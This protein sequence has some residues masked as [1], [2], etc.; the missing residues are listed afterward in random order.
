MHSK[1]IDINRPVCDRCGY[2]MSGSR[3]TRCP[4]C[5]SSDMSS[6]AARH[7]KLKATAARSGMILAWLLMLVVV[8]GGHMPAP[9]L[10]HSFVALPVLVSDVIR[11]EPRTFGSMFWASIAAVIAFCIGIL[12]RLLYNRSF[13]IRLIIWHVLSVAIGWVVVAVAAWNAKPA[14]FSIG[15]LLVSSLPLV[16]YFAKKYVCGIGVDIWNDRNIN[17]QAS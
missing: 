13:G 16:V 2:D 3:L 6:A 5:G 17:M 14:D 9:M 11:G 1:P 7:E 15:A 10:L 8:P 4:E 12:S